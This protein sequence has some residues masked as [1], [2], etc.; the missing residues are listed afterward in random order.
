MA[1]SDIQIKGGYLLHRINLDREGT[2]NNLK[3]VT[4]CSWPVRKEAIL[5]LSITDSWGGDENRS[6]REYVW[7]FY[8]PQKGIWGSDDGNRD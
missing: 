8:V 6:E 2:A 5:Y 1:Q 3:R 7:K 4:S